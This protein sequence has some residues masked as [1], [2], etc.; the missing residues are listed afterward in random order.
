LSW[1]VQLA[2]VLAAEP[3]LRRPGAIVSIPVAGLRG[4]AAVWRFRTVEP[5]APT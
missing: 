5:E 3:A 2:A 1:I 4:E